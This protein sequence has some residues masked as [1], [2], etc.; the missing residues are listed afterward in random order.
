MEFKGEVVVKHL[1]TLEDETLGLW[2]CK[3]CPSEAKRKKQG[4]N[5]GY[6]NMITH[7]NA[8]HPD[9][10]KDLANA[11]RHENQ[12]SANSLSSYFPKKVS[13]K[14]ANLYGWLEW[15]IMGGQ[16]FNFVDDCYV[17]RN[18]KREPISRNTLIKY[19]EKLGVIVEEKLAKILPDQFGLIIDGW[20]CN[21]EPFIA[22]FAT[23]T[24]DTGCAKTYL[25][26]C[27]VQD[28]LLEDVDDTDF[29]AES[30][31]DYISDELSLVGKGFQN[32]QFISGDNCSVNKKLCAL[33]T[34]AIRRPCPLIGCASHCNNCLVI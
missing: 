19:I 15:G 34:S 8:S 21:G 6:T 13:P 29:T 7:L 32:L 4:R 2:Q 22:I 28:E 30:I 18:T 16:P 20:S 11:M 3:L 9:W 31:G 1:F 33:I 10:K 5:G 17:R 25:L 14:S 24:D 26:C 27:G 23:W 12:M